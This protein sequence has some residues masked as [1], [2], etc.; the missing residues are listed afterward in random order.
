MAIPNNGSSKGFMGF[1]FILS[2]T[3]INIATIIIT[4]IYKKWKYG[5]NH[6]LAKKGDI[7]C[8]E[9]I[10]DGSVPIRISAALFQSGFIFNFMYLIAPKI[11]RNT[12]EEYEISFAGKLLLPPMTM[13]INGIAT[14]P[15][16]NPIREAKIEENNPIIIIKGIIAVI[17]ILNYTKK[18]TIQVATIFCLI[19]YLI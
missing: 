4:P 2:L 15:P 18:T 5:A 3:F 9:I 19:L 7:K 16:P 12:I 17:D 6:S 13:S 10:V 14:N 1:I 8:S 11:D